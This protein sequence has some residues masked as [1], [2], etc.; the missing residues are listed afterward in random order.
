MREDSDE[1]DVQ[2][3]VL[4]HCYLILDGVHDLH[5]D[6]LG[7]E[8][9]QYR[10]LK[11]SSAFEADQRL[12]LL[13]R[14]ETVE[15]V[16]EPN[17]KLAIDLLLGGKTSVMLL[18]HLPNACDEIGTVANSRNS[19]PKVKSVAVQTSEHENYKPDFEVEVEDAPENYEMRKAQMAA[20][21]IPERAGTMDWVDA[22]LKK[23]S[24]ALPHKAPVLWAQI[25]A[26]NHKEECKRIVTNHLRK[27]LGEAVDDDGVND[28]KRVEF[29]E[30]MSDPVLDLRGN[31][32]LSVLI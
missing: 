24:E 20:K 2:K 7:L 6:G 12:T 16:L 9:Q 13:A 27:I 18:V 8:T 23:Y 5:K 11:Q 31:V 1:E 17:K 4:R 30:S 19:F 10:H 22:L 32:Y 15:N 26:G 25:V 3:T 14:L 21:G 29:E 28:L